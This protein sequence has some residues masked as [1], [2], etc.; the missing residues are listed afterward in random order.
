MPNDDFVGFLRSGD[1]IDVWVAF[2]DG[3]PVGQIALHS[4]SS[5]EVMRLASERRRVDIDE[6]GVI[7]RL[8]VDPDHRRTGV[9]QRFFGL[10]TAGA[11]DRG[12]SR[13]SMSS[14]ASHRQSRSTN[15][16]DGPASEPSR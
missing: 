8:L 12:D 16:K 5:R 3:Q 2:V 11:I 13:S 15:E 7:A 10:A 14:S 6:I 1:A 4:S 9:A